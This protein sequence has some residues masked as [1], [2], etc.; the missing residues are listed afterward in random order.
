[1]TRLTAV[2][3]SGAYQ[4][5]Y[6][7]V[8][9]DLFK[10]EDVQILGLAQDYHDHSPGLGK[11]IN[12]SGLADGAV[13]GPKLAAGLLSGTALGGDL[14][15]TL[16]AAHIRLAN[17]SAIQA[18]QSTTQVRSLMVLGTDDHVAIY[19]AGA[20][21]IRFLNQAGTAELAH[22]DSGGNLVATGLVQSMN[23]NIWLTAGHTT[24]SSDGANMLLNTDNGA[25][26]TRAANGL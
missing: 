13:T 26:Y 3:F 25:V 11:L 24:I 6:A 15:G 10:K 7:T 21:L 1:M 5:T 14:I 18:I 23:G 12:T 20:G 2:H 9:T 19:N 4:F 8:T 22:V 17:G 16:G